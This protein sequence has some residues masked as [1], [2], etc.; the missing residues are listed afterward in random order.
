MRRTSRHDKDRSMTEP[1]LTGGCQCGAIRYRV[2]AEP[3]RA[4]VCYCRMCQKASGGPFMAFMRFVSGDI[5]W[6]AAA[7]Q[8]FRSSSLAERGFCGRCG[9]P[10][11]YHWIGGPHTSLTVNSL[12]DPEA[13]RPDRR[14]SPETETSWC[15]S[16]GEL[17]GKSLDMT[18]DSRFI[19][20]QGR[21]A[22]GP[23]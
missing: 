6:S 19:D 9:T 22:I 13:V 11:T 23:Y 3:R 20:Y 17:P 18:S 8:I 10:L 2:P 4:S 7:P 5:E 1:H 15:A 16:L 14:Y 12:D 21:A